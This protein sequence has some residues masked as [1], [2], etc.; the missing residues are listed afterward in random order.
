ML[1]FMVALS[2]KIPGNGYVGCDSVMCS[3]EQ[4]EQS[5]E[6]ME[7]ALTDPEVAEWPPLPTQETCEI[8]PPPI[9]HTSTQKALKTLILQFSLPFCVHTYTHSPERT[10]GGS[11]KEAASTCKA[12]FFPQSKQWSLC[13]SPPSPPWYGLR[14]TLP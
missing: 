1:P 4:R 7:G 9:P 8:P 3:Q 13:W 10:A 5:R 2:T 6:R 12:N 11:G 14:P